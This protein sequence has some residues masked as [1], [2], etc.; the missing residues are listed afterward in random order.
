MYLNLLESIPKVLE[1]FT[2]HFLIANGSSQEL[3]IPHMI[4]I[5]GAPLNPIKYHLF[6][7]QYFS[8]SSFSFKQTAMLLVI[9]YIFYLIFFLWN[10]PAL[11]KQEISLTQYAFKV[12]FT[13]TVF[14]FIT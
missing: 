13:I 8:L 5:N 14:T 9:R 4:T 10:G 3:I 11:R 6:S 7:F 1:N 12:C 2:G